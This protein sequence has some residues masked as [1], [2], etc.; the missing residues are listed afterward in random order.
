MVASKFWNWRAFEAR[1]AIR[2]IRL[3]SFK[4]EIVQF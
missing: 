3:R 1:S 2:E 4:T